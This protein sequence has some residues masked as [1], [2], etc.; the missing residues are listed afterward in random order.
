MMI[1]D[2]IPKIIKAILLVNLSVNLVL[3]MQLYESDMKQRSS[4]E[5]GEHEPPEFKFC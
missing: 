5:R 1:M 4:L 3:S 2:I